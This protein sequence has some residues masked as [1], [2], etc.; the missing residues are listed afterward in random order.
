FAPVD[1]LKKQSSFT[2]TTEQFFHD[3][4]STDT[5]ISKK[6]AKQ[7]Y[8]ISFDSLDVPLL[9]KAIQSVTWK[10]RNYLDVKKHL[11]GEL[12]DLK[13]LT[14]TPFLRELYWKVKD[15]ADLQNLILSSLLKQKTRESFAAF[16]E[17]ILQEPPLTTDNSDYEYRGYRMSHITYQT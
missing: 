1:T 15:S 9:K 11:I 7:L 14:I 6:A 5:L 12:A 8:K 16:K 13:D 17:L 10:T 4:F 2:R 3:Y